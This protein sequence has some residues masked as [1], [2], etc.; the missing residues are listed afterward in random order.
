VSS[1]PTW[2]FWNY[3]EQ[4]QDNGKD[5]NLQDRRDSPCVARGVADEGVIDPVY[6]EDTE[7]Q[8]RE[9][10]AD[11]HAAACLGTELSLQDRHCRVDETQT[12]SGDYTAD[13]EVCATERGCLKNGTDHA[14]DGSDTD[15]LATT[16]LLANEC[17]SHGT[18]KATDW[19][20]N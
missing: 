8:R 3:E 2:R 16:Q 14:D 19:K 15:A 20:D 5:D 4:T 7:I 11:V 10:R 18:D 12:D 1:K 17:S 6:E 9:L 13:N